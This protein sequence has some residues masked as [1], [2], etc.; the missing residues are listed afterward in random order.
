M[1]TATT[2]RSSR[3]RRLFS[4]TRSPTKNSSPQ[5][6]RMARKF[7][8]SRFEFCVFPL[9]RRLLQRHRANILPPAPLAPPPLPEHVEMLRDRL[10]QPC[11]L[12]PDAQ[13]KIPLLF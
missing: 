2:T 10:D 8:V 3:W 13:L 12:R 7:R 9:Q 6:S 11:L 1:T 5:E 4:P